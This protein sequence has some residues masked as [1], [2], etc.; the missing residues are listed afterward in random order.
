MARNNTQIAAIGGAAVGGAALGWAAWRRLSLQ[1][2]NCKINRGSSIAVLG[3]GFAGLNTAR[4]LARLLPE[5]HLCRIALI[6]QNNFLLFTPMLTEVAGGELDPRHIVA[7]PRRLSRR[8]MFEKARVRSIDLVKRTIALEI[9]PGVD[10]TISVDQLVIALGSVSNYHGI[11]G[12]AEHSLSMK[13][14]ADAIAIRNRVLGCLERAS[15]EPDAQLRSEI[16]TFVVAGGGFTGVETMAAVNDMARESARH[17]PSLSADQITTNLIDPG[18]RLL[19]E[20]EPDLAAFASRKLQERGVKILLNTRITGAGEDFVDLEGGQRIA[21]RMVVWAAGVTPNPLIETLDCRRGH[22]GGIIVDEYCRVPDR[23]GVWA[24]GDCA[25]IPVPGGH[26]TQPATAQ[27][28]TREGEQV[29]RNIVA[30]LRGEQP[31]PF[32]FQRIG[33]LALVGRHSG[34]GQIYGL[35]F[36]GFLAWALW[37]GVYLSKMPGMAQRSRILLD[38]MLDAIFGREIAEMPINTRAEAGPAAASSLGADR[39][40]EVH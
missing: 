32:T 33:E 38:W 11:P 21:T 25:E 26:G 2:K 5:K 27:N 40:H 23:P 16:L 12:L 24:I 31:R 20:L 18:D 37:R 4:E 17:Y 22:H 15:E 1:R 8:V 35:Q 39:L 28:A 3:A 14:V 34:V 29:A 19:H 9:E 36:S 6:D 10:R 30:V 13:S 7:S